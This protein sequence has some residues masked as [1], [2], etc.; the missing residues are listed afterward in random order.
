M[1]CKAWYHS[2]GEVPFTTTGLGKQRSFQSKVPIAEVRAAAA[3]GGGG[4]CTNHTTKLDA[5][6]E[7]SYS[8]LAVE[9][10]FILLGVYDGHGA[11]G[12]DASNIARRVVVKD[13]T[14]AAAGRLLTPSSVGCN[15]WKACWS[16]RVAQ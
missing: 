1:M 15:S 7:D 12:H 10:S 9:K 2:C 8:L 5:Y 4:L 16:R 14:L 11:Y 13:R 6:R 3:A